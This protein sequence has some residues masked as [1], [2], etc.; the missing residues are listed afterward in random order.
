[1]KISKSLDGSCEADVYHVVKLM[2]LDDKF[3]SARNN[4]TLQERVKMLYI[5]YH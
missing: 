1:M 3:I 2:I 5:F 4:I